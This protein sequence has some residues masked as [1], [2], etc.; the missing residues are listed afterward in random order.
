[1]GYS[2]SV[3]PKGADPLSY[4]ASKQ[5]LRKVFLDCDV[6]DDKVLTK[7]EVKVAFD[8][9]GALFPGFRAWKALR[10]VD[11]NRDGFISMDELDSLIEY[12]YQRGYINVN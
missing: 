10:R 1:M 6:D 5:Q 3:V 8:R 12:A 7:E 9:F 2:Y 4:R 11:K